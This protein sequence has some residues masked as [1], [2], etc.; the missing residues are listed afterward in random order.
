MADA[1]VASTLN[2]YLRENVQLSPKDRESAHAF[3]S[4][5]FTSPDV[6]D[7]TGMYNEFFTINSYSS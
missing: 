1:V 2:E 4:E 6:D 7:F 5:F 3:I